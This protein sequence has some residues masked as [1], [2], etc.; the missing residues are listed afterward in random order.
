MV[1]NE[2][3]KHESEA[4]VPVTKELID[5]LRRRGMFIE[6]RK[7]LEEYHDWKRKQ[8]NTDR[9]VVNRQER[10]VYNFLNKE[11]RRAYSEHEKKRKKEG[12]VK[13]RK[14]W[15]EEKKVLFMRCIEDFR[16]IC[17]KKKLKDY[18]LLSKNRCYHDSKNTKASRLKPKAW[19]YIGKQFGISG[20]RA[21]KNYFIYKRFRY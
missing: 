3:P 13:Q 1:E 6:A 21:K 18:V 5:D 16:E 14:S 12:K 20:T 17:V 4:L 2:E 11:R 10:K 8:A 15:S 7:K 9:I 19:V